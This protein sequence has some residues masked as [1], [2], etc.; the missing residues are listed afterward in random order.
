MFIYKSSGRIQVFF[1]FGTLVSLYLLLTNFCDCTTKE[2]FFK[3]EMM[4]AF[5]LLTLSLVTTLPLATTSQLFYFMDKLRKRTESVSRV[6][7]ASTPGLRLF[8]ARYLESVAEI[9]GPLAAESQWFPTVLKVWD[10]TH[11]LGR[12]LFSPKWW[13]L[14]GH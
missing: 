13:A 10:I 5:S 9:L 7:N 12:K 3:G 1:F 8:I 11:L 2:M 4:G 14:C 6:I